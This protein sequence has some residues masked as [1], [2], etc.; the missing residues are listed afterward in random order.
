M[1]PDSL[2]NVLNGHQ[3][4]GSRQSDPP[5]RVTPDPEITPLSVVNVLYP[6]GTEQVHFLHP[7][8]GEEDR[9]TAAKRD[10]KELEDYR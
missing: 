10:V 7:D 6:C 9:I 8:G 4:Q 2:K 1:L 5:E 3:R